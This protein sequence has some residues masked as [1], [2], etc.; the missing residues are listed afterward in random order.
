MFIGLALSTVN[1]VPSV[2]IAGRCAREHRDLDKAAVSVEVQ[3]VG[4]YSKERTVYNMAYDRA[5]FADLTIHRARPFRVVVEKDRVVEYDPTAHQYAEKAKGDES[6]DSA[7]RHAAGVLDELVASLIE[8][9][10]V[11]N[12]LKSVRFNESWTARID[13]GRATL[14][15]D[16][17]DSHTSVTVDTSTHRLMAVA[18]KSRQYGTDWKFNYRQPLK[19]IAFVAPNGARKV[20]EIRPEIVTPTY[21]SAATKRMCEKV[22]ARYDH[23]KGLAYTVTS[24]DEKFDVWID[25]ARARQR[26]T[27]ADWLVDD[28]N[29]LLLDLGAKTAVEGKT[30]M[31]SLVDTVS[32][33]G[34][35]IEPLLKLLLRGI[36]PFRFY[37]G[38]N[39]NV[40]LTGSTKFS[41]EVCSMLE[42]DSP[43]G[44]LM[45]VARDNDGFVLS[46]MSIPKDSNSP[47][48]RYFKPLAVGPESFRLAKPQG[49]ASRS[50]DEVA[51]KANTP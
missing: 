14:S 25:G 39:A 33:T 50:L 21:A 45:M 29:V 12:W 32:T 23:V 44:K 11:A 16:S 18:I 8:P 15:N 5:G 30:E 42:S 2:Y 6:V 48:T 41:G 26:D 34:T 38:Q 28:K 36:N 3:T 35:R 19:D 47:V 37:L 9:N 46:V 51:A 43:A 20:N 40:R 22:F 10:G 4:I 27:H 24:P 31:T 1:F 17:D 7:L 13:G 49:W